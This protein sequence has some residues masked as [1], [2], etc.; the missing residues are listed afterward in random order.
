MPWASNSSNMP[1]GR[2]I[3]SKKYWYLIYNNSSYSPILIG[4]HLWSSRG[5][6]QRWLHYNKHFPS[7]Y[8]NSGN[9]KVVNRFDEAAN[10]TRSSFPVFGRPWVLF[11]SG[12]QIFFG[13][14]SRHV[15]KFSFHLSLPNSNFYH[16]FSLIKEKA[17]SFL[18][19][20]KILE[21]FQSAKAAS[22]I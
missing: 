1:W 5:Q 20:G 9:I 18:E 15:D 10:R 6:T 13:P 12:T 21:Q 2:S 11:L 4:S 14:R 8:W 19:V 7:L 17:V 22:K 3:W 16:L